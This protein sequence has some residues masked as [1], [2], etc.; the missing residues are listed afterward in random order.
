MTLFITSNEHK[1]REIRDAMHKT[2]LELQWEKTQYVEIQGDTTAEIS[3]DSAR[4]LSDRIAK[5]FFLEDTGLYIDSLNGF[6]GPYSSYVASTVGNEGILK[7]L[8]GKGRKA[9]FMTVITYS[10]KGVYTQFEGV[11]EGRISES[12]SGNFGFG[13]DPIFIPE[14]QSRTLAEM[15]VDEKNRIS[16]RSRALS[17]LVEHIKG[18]R[19]A[20][21]LHGGTDEIK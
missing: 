15:T 8:S 19:E 7:L 12:V 18:E 20:H 10:S 2:G 1:F 6:P 16:H 4:R 5:D 11:L 3:L 14:G 9:R 21:S 13:F 17:K